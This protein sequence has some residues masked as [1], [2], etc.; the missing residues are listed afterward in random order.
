[1]ARY[2][3]C[4]LKVARA[5]GRTMSDDEIAAIYERVHK[6]AL[7]IRAGRAKPAAAGGDFVMQ[8]ANLAA[9][10]LQAEAALYQ[11]QAHLQIVRIAGQKAEY[12][13]LVRAGL[14]PL[15]AVDGLI[16]RDYSGRFN[17]Q[18]LEQ[19]STGLK[20][21]FESKV[22]PAWEA[23]GRDY[24][25][26][27]QDRAKSI[28]LLRELRGEDSGN[29]LA[30]QGAKAFHDAA[31]EARQTFNAA[32]G[33]VGRLDDWGMPQHHSQERVAMAGRDAWIDAITPLLD[34]TRYIDEAGVP[35]TDARLR[36]FLVKAW[37]TIATDGLANVE[38]GKPTGLGKRA[39]RHAEHRQI[40]FRDAESLLSYWEQFGERS[41]IE[42]LHGHIS[43]MARDIALVE[44]FGPNPNTTFQTL[45]DL[46]LQAA[47]KL[48]PT[49]TEGLKARADA[50]EDL[51][52]YSAM[53]G[54][55]LT[56][57]RGLRIAADAIAHL[58]VA[59]KLGTAPITSFFG[60]KVMMEAVR[61]L[62]NVPALQAW[63][64]ELALLN[65]ANATDRRFLH[66]QGLMLDSVRSGLQRFY[67]GLGQSS[68][69]GKIANAVMR[70]SGMQAINDIRKGAFG[71]TLM[72]AIGHEIQRGVRFDALA[73]SDIRLLRNY[74]I[75]DADWNTWRLARLDD[76]GAN[77]TLLTPE[78]ISR[79]PDAE[80][81]SAGVI[82]QA[83]GPEAAQS[84]RR[85]AIVKLLGAINTES[86]FAIVTPGW[87][88]RA[89]FYAD[90]KRGTVTGEIMRSWLQF[91]SFPV[92]FF[93]R[94][95]DLVANGDT[96][97]SKATMA[98]YLVMATTAA[99]AMI[100]QTKEMLSGKDPRKMFDDDW[101]KFWASSFI[102]GGALGIY[103]DF[104][105]SANQTRFGSG[106]V[107]ALAGP[108]IGPLLELGLVQPLG[109]ARSVLEGKKTGEQ[110]LRHL[111]AQ[112]IGDAKGFLPGSNIWYTRAALDH[113]VMQQ[114]LEALNP[115]YLSS[116]RSRT[117]REFG[118]DWWWAPGE[119]SPDRA[120]DLE[121]SIK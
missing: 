69:T 100:V 17:V 39:N 95:M 116:T 73:D 71:V 107:E 91:K 121:R 22:L 31:E 64:N 70:I 13:Q 51:F 7:D 24:L 56:K 75:S 120:P 40:H 101:M 26:F 66:R 19:R 1:L 14:K 37:H 11:R 80:L 28:D 68:M 54:A 82:G 88:D 29:A 98:A 65:P 21:Y 52:R 30:R 90:L 8:A 32:G 118:Q 86:E 115:G 15:D 83:D 104:L 106:P 84:A 27:F 43:T 89:Q 76:R 58:N 77:H 62:N 33:D 6:A 49:Q 59:G 50:L 74:G 46:A 108:T 99:G 23:L 109:A 63:R 5:A 4:I 20:A 81:R 67:E 93:K 97:A 2:R 57:S 103:G 85:N 112:T 45:R 53:G 111:A 41:L 105:Y 25:G 36:D 117:Q 96:P 114:V 35:W 48:E 102:A 34:R 79:I 10:Q 61:H 87:R 78:A 38:P 94:S 92:A 60:D 12:D 9:E 119:L 72:D 110:A 3:D 55:Q 18:S 16:G 47:A 44:Q 42:I 113:L